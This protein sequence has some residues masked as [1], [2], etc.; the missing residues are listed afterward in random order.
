MKK[1]SRRIK[2]LREADNKITRFKEELDVLITSEEFQEKFRGYVEDLA[3]YKSVDKRKY[4]R[5]TDYAAI[6]IMDSNDMYQEAYLA[7][8]EAYENVD[9]DKEGGEIW[10]FL[11]KTTTLNL[12]RQIR[13]S[14]DGIRTPE[15]AYFESQN[16]NVLT[17]IFG[18]LEQMFSKNA[19]EVSLTK[20]ET[21]LV[22]AFMDVHFDEYLDLTREG[23]RDIR[24]NERAILKS[25]YGLDEPRLTYAELSETYRLGQGTI[26]QVKS[27]A[28]KR[29]QSEESKEK[30]ADFLHEYRI[31][32]K[33]DTEKYRK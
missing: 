11:K 4:A 7:F 2:S 23:N 26:R 10:T 19:E 9:F 25:L 3:R 21:D 33:A 31:V 8:L 16:T 5:S 13:S 1:Y 15:R 27:R 6:G 30:I 29:L 12:E 18:N 17:G 20:W 28:I 32:T 14:K 22:G 24:K